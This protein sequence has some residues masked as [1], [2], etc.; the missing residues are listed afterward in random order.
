MKRRFPN[1]SREAV[2]TARLYKG[3]NSGGSLLK[4]DVLRR[5]DWFSANPA[6]YG[7][8]RKRTKPKGQK[9]AKCMKTEAEP[10]GSRTDDDPI[11]CRRCTVPCAFSL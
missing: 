9:A 6:T 4:P 3:N 5:R 10:T 1:L 11:S 7:N 8:V 2:L